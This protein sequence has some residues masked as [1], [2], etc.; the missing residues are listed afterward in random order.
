M[1]YP[2][3]RCLVRGSSRRI[4]DCEVRRGDQPSPKP[5][6]EY[7]PDQPSTQLALGPSFPGSSTTR[8][9]RTPINERRFELEGSFHINDTA[10]QRRAREGARRATDASVRCN[11]LL[12]GMPSDIRQEVHRFNVVARR[13]NAVPVHSDQ[14]AVFRKA[15]NPSLGELGPS[16]LDDREGRILG[17]CSD[18]LFRSASTRPERLRTAP[19]G[20]FRRR[21]PA[22]IPDGPDGSS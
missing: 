17:N 12:A 7:Q 1:R 2:N 4:K 5:T 20:I 9:E 15:R 13:T 11:G 6:L 19:L 8:K 21:E 18:D 10:V 14:D 22:A 3:P 16:D